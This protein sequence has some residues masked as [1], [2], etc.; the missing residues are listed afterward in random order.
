L[1][2]IALDRRFF[3]WRK[4]E[5]SDPDLVLRW[6]L[7]KDLM[8][9]DGVLARRRIVLLA[10][11][12]SGKTEE[13]RE[14][15]R[16]RTATGQFA[17]YATVEDVDRD[18]LEGALGAA[19]R[20]RFANWRGTDNPGWFFIDSIDEAKL[21]RVRF[22]RALRR[23]ADGILGTE[24]R[25]HLVLSCR[26]TDW[27]STRDLE[28]LKEALRIPRDP[29]LPPPPS[30]DELLVQVLHTR[31]VT[32]STPAAEDPSVLLMAPLDEERV[33]RF[34]SAKAV[35]DVNSFIGQV[36][37]GNLWRFARRPL[38]LDWLVGFWRE[39]GRLGSLA[40]A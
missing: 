18:G 25:A 26:L 4:G 9:W 12:G 6:G 22:D 11:A 28:R 24:R 13:M 5:L 23:I 37:A 14:Q 1:T 38:D 31:Q 3:E 7:T 10:E 8:P 39:H 15:A 35:P 16:V 40:D 19:D 30:P 34:A 20:A 2:T 29:E 33:R 32:T 36:E 17:V 21:G 27:E